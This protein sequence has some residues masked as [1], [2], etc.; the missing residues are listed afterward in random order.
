M[1]VIVDHDWNPGRCLRS[2]DKLSLTVSR[3]SLTLLTKRVLVP[4]LSETLSLSS[5]CRSCK[6]FSTFART[7]KTELF[8]TTLQARPWCRLAPLIRLRHMVLY[9][10]VFIDWF[11]IEICQSPIII[12][13]WMFFTV[14]DNVF[15]VYWYHVCLCVDIL[16]LYLLMSL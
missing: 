14:I 4:L 8:G 9:K 13:L 15:T 11:I 16:H 1:S 2:A 7:L 12:I 3:T 10:C 5:N 6:L